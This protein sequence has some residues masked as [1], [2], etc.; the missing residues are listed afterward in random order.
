[1]KYFVK[2]IAVIQKGL[3][4]LL[5]NYAMQ[6]IICIQSSLPDCPASSSS[7]YPAGEKMAKSDEYMWRYNGFGTC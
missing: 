6:E 4:L 1:M 5:I 2:K 7:V 3:N